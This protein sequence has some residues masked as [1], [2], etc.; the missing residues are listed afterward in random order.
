[1]AM[2]TVTE[3]AKLPYCISRQSLSAGLVP[4]IPLLV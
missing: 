4:A 1:M 2:D 3:W